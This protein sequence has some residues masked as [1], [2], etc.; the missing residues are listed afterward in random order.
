PSPTIINKRGDTMTTTVAKERATQS[1]KAHALRA[2]HEKDEAFIIPNPWDVGTARLLA[3]LGFEA[4][5]TTSA[6]YAFSTGQPDFSIGR[7]RMLA[8]VADIVA[9]TDLPVSADLENGFGDGPDT[10]AETITMAAAAG[11]A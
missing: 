3:A 9:A 10:V 7:E 2:L 6:G 4:L 5:A 1:A 8:H 11:L